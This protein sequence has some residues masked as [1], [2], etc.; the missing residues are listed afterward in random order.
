MPAAANAC[1]GCGAAAAAAACGRRQVGGRLVG[2]S[3][4]FSYAHERANRLPPL[5]DTPTSQTPG[6]K[7]LPP[8]IFS[9]HAV[10]P[11]SVDVVVAKPNDVPHALVGGVRWQNLLILSHVQDGP[12]LH[13]WH[14]ATPPQSYLLL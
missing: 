10:A 3:V 12:D 4:C 14:R 1:G 11:D 6:S 8:N 7:A 2:V 9:A 13:G 5:Q